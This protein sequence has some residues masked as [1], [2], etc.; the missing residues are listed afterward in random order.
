MTLLLVHGGGFSGSCWD[1]TV[2]H[3][4][5]PAIAVDLP[6]R[7]TSPGDLAAASLDDFAAKVVAEIETRDLDGVVL[8]GH[9][10]AGMTLPLVVGRVPE[11]LA[12]VVFV[13][14]CV[15]EHGRST[16]DYLD[17]AEVHDVV[18]RSR[19]SER[20]PEPLDADTATAIFCNDM[21]GATTSYTLSI[22]C[23]EALGVIQEPIDLS[24]MAA[25]V[26]RAWIRLTNDQ[27]LT[28]AM[29]DSSIAHLGETTVIDLDA[30]HM[31]MISQPRQLAAILDRLHDGYTASP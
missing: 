16:L 31:A 19:S 24:G 26:P 18:E 6:G 9:S 7:G 12:G 22:M 13:S 11:R 4:R 5:A 8:V 3:L 29:Q 21:D 17:R 20:T 10:L 23:P 2:Q 14:C 1:R 27:I 28:P 30:G 25:P 15:P